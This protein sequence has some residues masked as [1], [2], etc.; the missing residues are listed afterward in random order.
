MLQK[1]YTSQFSRFSIENIALSPSYFY[2]INDLV[3]V[4][5]KNGNTN[6]CY[7]K[8]MLMMYKCCG[9]IVSYFGNLWFFAV[10]CFQGVFLIDS[11]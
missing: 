11:E 2:H 4:Q 1:N 5:W 10:L 3:N 7:V 8:I 6:S 9:N